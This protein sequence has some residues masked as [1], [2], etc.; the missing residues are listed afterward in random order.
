MVVE[1]GTYRRMARHI[2]VWNLISSRCQNFGELSWL[3]APLSHLPQRRK[4]SQDQWKR[5]WIWPP[6]PVWP[7]LLRK[8][9]CCGS[10]SYTWKVRSHLK[11]RPFCLALSSASCC[12]YSV[13]LGLL[14][15]KQVLSSESAASILSST[16]HMLKRIERRWTW[17]SRKDSFWFAGT[18]SHTAKLRVI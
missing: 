11:T 17:E 4:F 2:I 7:A 3:L 6:W 10:S 16:E 14:P 12:F 13:V 8:M 1:F 5:S 18:E 9:R 15:P